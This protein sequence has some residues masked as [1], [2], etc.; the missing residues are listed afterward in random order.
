[1]TQ[2]EQIIS[3]LRIRTKSTCQEIC[4]EM[5]GENIPRH[6]NASISSLLRIL[7]LNNIV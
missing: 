5:Y 2:K 3:I 1:M 7:V 4:K 6:I